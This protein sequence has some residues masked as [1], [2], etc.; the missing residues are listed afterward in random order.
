MGG[1]RTWTT[2]PSYWRQHVLLAS[3]LVSLLSEKPSSSAKGKT[4]R[5]DG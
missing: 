2:A 1:R 3:P 4:E 5:G